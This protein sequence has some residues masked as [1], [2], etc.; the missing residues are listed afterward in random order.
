MSSVFHLIS[1]WLDN[2]WEGRGNYWRMGGQREGPG[3]W[4][5]SE[6]GNGVRL[7]T[8]PGDEPCVA[9]QSSL[10][11]SLSPP[12]P[13]ARAQPGLKRGGNRATYYPQTHNLNVALHQVNIIHQL[14]ISLPPPLSHTLSLSLSF[15]GC[16]DHTHMQAR[17]GLKCW[18]RIEHYLVLLPSHLLETG[19]DCNIGMD[20]A[21]GHN[22]VW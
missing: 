17:S 8:V 3:G 11:L 1:A 12:L 20:D 14:G 4:W 7:L 13:T 10:S 6:R 9:Q 15:T 2:K 16:Y 22:C 5:G 21:F 18:F 19:S